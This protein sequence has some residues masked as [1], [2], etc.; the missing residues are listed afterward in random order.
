MGVVSGALQLSQR[1]IESGLTD[2]RMD[3]HE[4]NASDLI[5]RSENSIDIYG[6]YVGSWLSNHMADLTDFVAQKEGRLRLIL[7]A[8]D[9]SCVTSFEEKLNKAEP[10]RLREKIEGTTNIFQSSLRNCSTP[11]GTA[12][13]YYQPFPPAYSLFRFDDNAYIIPY[14]QSPGRGR[15]PAY[16]LKNSGG[17]TLFSLYIADL[18]RLLTDY[19]RP[20]WSTS[21]TNV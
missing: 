9:A 5:R 7:L 10:T 21:E 8:P 11:N 2:I 14:N 1:V 13:L 18:E 19:A 17:V 20:H 3:F 4:I 15:A 12:T 6:L 16:L